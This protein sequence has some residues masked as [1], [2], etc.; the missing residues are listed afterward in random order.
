MRIIAPSM[1]SADFGNLDRDVEMVN[2][3]AAGW[4][5]LDVMDG[6]FVPNIS[7]GI[8]VTKAIARLARKPMDAHLMIVEPHK[9][10]RKFA[11]L[12]VEYLSV[13]YEACKSNLHE[14]LA[15]IRNSGMKAGIAINPETSEDFLVPYLD[16]A[17]YILVMSV[18]PGFSG[19]K[20]I[21]GSVEKVARVKAL[22][23]RE[24][25]NCFIQIDGGVGVDNIAALEAAG[26]SVFVAGS[27]AFSGADPKANIAAL[28]GK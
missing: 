19:Q 12:G 17:D 8:P 11:D 5:H 26:A 23:E 13:H 14:T 28:A 3:S 6:V 15:L 1:L 25:A 2:E 16:E 18:H 7:Y 24:K 9:Y 21:E 4:F 10:V 27:A 22:I 20:F